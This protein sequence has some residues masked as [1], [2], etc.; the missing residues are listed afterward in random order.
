MPPFR[1]LS[2]P[3]LWCSPALFPCPWSQNS[4]V[5]VFEISIRFL[6][7]LLSAY[8]L[9]GDQMYKEKALDIGKRLLPAYDT[10][11]GVP[12]AVINLHTGA[13]HNWGWASG[14]CS[15]LSEFGSMQLEWN[16]LSLI[17]GDDRFAQ[18]VRLI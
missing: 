10:P 1:H 17:T 2:D 13:S 16:Y 8:A 14:G 6:G 4:G 11:T 12:K 5:S 15:I 7:G 3:D 9:T 18:K